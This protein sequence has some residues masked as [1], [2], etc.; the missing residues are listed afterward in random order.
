[1]DEVGTRY[2]KQRELATKATRTIKLFG[3]LATSLSLVIT[4]VQLF[5]DLMT[6]FVTGN[7]FT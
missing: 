2:K 1:M 6:C 4:K 5:G 3:G 7:K